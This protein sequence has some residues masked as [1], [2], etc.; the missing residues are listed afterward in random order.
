MTTRDA[1]FVG[2][3]PELYEKHLVPVIF[4]PF[5]EDLVAR[6]GPLEHGDVLEIAAGTGA[7]TRKLLPCLG[8]GARLF[9]TDLND[10]M[11]RLARTRMPKDPRVTWRTADA[12]SLPFPD[13]SFDLVI[14][15]FGV[16]FF[17]D[18]VTGLREVRRVLRPGGEFRF[19]VW[20]SFEHNPFGR[21]AHRTI[22]SF[23]PADP[24]TFY[25]TPFG[26]HDP[27]LIQ[28]MLR[29]TGFRETAVEFVP[30]EAV[31]KSARNF[32]TGLVRGNPVSADIAARGTVDIE[33][34]VE[35]LEAELGKAGGVAPHRSP[36]R[37]V[38]IRATK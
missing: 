33:A 8:E 16:M 28:S 1:Q 5:A 19:N 26:F 37:A 11:M 38:V 2:S 4:N 18:K 10:A 7:V 34:V 21:L 6:I 31:A 35:A 20:D 17:E 29:T 24:P 13:D 27:E 32:A 15:Q 36:M 25:F 22:A 14:C 12:G 9:A 3:I 30:R 23:F